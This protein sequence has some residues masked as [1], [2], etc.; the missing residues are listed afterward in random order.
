[1]HRRAGGDAALM[2]AAMM[3]SLPAHKG[4]DVGH[5]AR[6]QAHRRPGRCV[7]DVSVPRSSDAR[8]ILRMVENGTICRL[9]SCGS[10][11]ERPS[12]LR[13]G[14]PIDPYRQLH[15]ARSRVTNID[16][17]RQPR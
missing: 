3:G 13:V 17:L 6:Q 11:P 16:D 14:C 1:M 7:G 15:L 12:S 8:R 2:G 10:R 4:A 5:H 9:W